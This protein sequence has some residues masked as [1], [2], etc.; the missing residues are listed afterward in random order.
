MN[1]R[2][3]GRGRGR[4][5]GDRWVGYMGGMTDETAEYVDNATGHEICDKRPAAMSS[6]ISL[7]NM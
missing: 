3:W 2:A 5:R 7:R 4:G 1:A 6:C